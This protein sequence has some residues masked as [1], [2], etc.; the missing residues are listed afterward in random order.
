MKVKKEAHNKG[1]S[2]YHWCTICKDLV[3]DDPNKGLSLY[4]YC[5]H[6]KKY[7]KRVYM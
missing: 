5:T 1:K 6:D 3:H 7:W 4:R 2:L